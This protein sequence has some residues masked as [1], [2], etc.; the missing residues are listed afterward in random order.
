[1]RRVE[2]VNVSKLSMRWNLEFGVASIVLFTVVVDS[3]ATPVNLHFYISV[4][5]ALCSN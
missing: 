2:R 1:M 4:H 3:E 5:T